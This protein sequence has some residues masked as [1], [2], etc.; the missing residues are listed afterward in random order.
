MGKA[1]VL[2]VR[3]LRALLI[4]AWRSHRVRQV[5]F[6]GI[7]IGV[8]HLILLGGVKIAR[9]ANQELVYPHAGGGYMDQGVFEIKRYVQPSDCNAS[10]ERCDMYPAFVKAMNACE[11]LRDAQS[12]AYPGCKFIVPEGYHTLSQT[13]SMCRHHVVEGAG[14]SP[15]ERMMT[16]LETSAK[17]AFHFKGSGECGAAGT[18]NGGAVSISGLQLGCNA[19]CEAAG[20]AASGSFGILAERTFY[21][22]DM[23]I[24][25]FTQGI[26][27]VGFLETIT[28]V[29]LVENVW[30]KDNRHAGFYIQGNDTSAG[31]GVHLNY[32]QNCQKATTW[33]ARQIGHGS[34]NTPALNDCAGLWDASF[35]GNHYFGAHASGQQDF[36]SLAWFRGI[37][38]GKDLGTNES[39]IFGAYIEDHAGVLNWLGV[40]TMAVGGL[41]DWQDRGTSAGFRLRGS[42]FNKLQFINYVDNSE[43]VGIKLGSDT[44]HTVLTVT[45]LGSDL[46]EDTAFYLRWD[47]TNKSLN[48]KVDST[49]E[50]LRLIGMAGSPL[51]AKGKWWTDCA[52]AANMT[53]P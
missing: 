31:S 18:G 33:N 11:K 17:I 32:D 45:P 43:R 14:G 16:I 9:V 25:S 42:N 20:D 15:A 19:T 40:S 7:A 29:W 48:W 50:P 5:L 10:G 37:A 8:G 39:A 30:F 13:V 44:A 28:N 46:S 38:L 4:L 21:A 1:V 41:G 49:S 53:C 24:G 47:P 22:R 26:R 2:F 36:T 27:L 23:I 52:Q 34:I 12:S 35:L 6:M 3:F 51:G